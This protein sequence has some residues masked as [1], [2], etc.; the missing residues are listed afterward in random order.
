MALSVAAQLGGLRV[1]EES[2]QVVELQLIIPESM[3]RMH[4]FA[5]VMCVHTMLWLSHTRVT[6]THT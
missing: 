1:G 4:A 5:C 3:H 2:L 6:R